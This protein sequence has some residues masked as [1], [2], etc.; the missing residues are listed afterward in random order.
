MNSGLYECEVYH[1]RLAPKRHEFRYRLFYLDLDLDEIP[2]LTKKLFFLSRNRWNLFTFR[3][4]DHLDLGRPDIRSNLE[5]WL[6]EQ[7][8]KLERGSRIRLVTLPRILGY[9]FN[10]VCFYFISSP[11]GQPQHAVAEVSN[12]FRE[13]KPWLI[14]PSTGLPVINLSSL[15]CLS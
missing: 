5:A 7:G 3:D 8:V 6:E 4:R 9:F 13:M 11:D 12:T 15:I 14:A 2:D 10:P 1:C